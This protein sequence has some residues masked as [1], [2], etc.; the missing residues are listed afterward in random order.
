MTYLWPTGDPIRV[1]LD[2]EGL[3]QRFWWRSAWHL[4]SAVANRWR[5]RT[6]W[7]SA[8]A[9]REYVKVTT[10]DGLLCTLYRDL[11]ASNGAQGDDVWYFAELYD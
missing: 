2:D 5:V 8:A 11:E 6:T 3:P 1:T 10:T 4:V 7:W 9:W